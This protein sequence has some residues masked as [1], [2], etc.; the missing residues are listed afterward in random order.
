MYILYIHV[1]KHK[2]NNMAGELT[3]PV[4]VQWK[5]NGTVQKRTLYVPK[6]TKFDSE[7]SGVHTVKAKNQTISLNKADA[8][9]LLGA[10]HANPDNEKYKLDQK[11]FNVLHEEWN[12]S[13]AKETGQLCNN[14]AVR[15]GT[16]AGRISAA[17]FNTGGEY[18]V[19]RKEGG[20]EYRFSIFLGKGK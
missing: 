14:T 20:S 15:S 8:Y 7:K 9:I 13:F 6:G 19:N 17:F 16:G 2:E 4:V 10:S 11:D 1:N 5:E 3:V 12:N 18:V